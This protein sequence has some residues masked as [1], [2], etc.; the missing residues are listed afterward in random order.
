MPKYKLAVTP[1]TDSSKEKA[2]SVTTVLLTVKPSSGRMWCKCSRSGVKGDCPLCMRRLM[3]QIES[4]RGSAIIHKTIVGVIMA[5]SPC[6]A[7]IANQQIVKPSRVLPE[8]PKKMAP[9]V[10]PK[11]RKL[12]SKKAIVAPIKMMQ[13]YKRIQCS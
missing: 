4:N 6:A 11:M 1:E 13:K 12:N 7:V 8:S 2:R 9:L 10:R 3:I 5:P